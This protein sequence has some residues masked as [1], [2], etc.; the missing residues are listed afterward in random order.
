MHGP[1]RTVN[2]LSWDDVRL[3]LAL[4]RARTVGAAGRSLGID[5]STVSRR[6]ATLEELLA[7]KL[8]ERGHHG[9]V[10][11]EA[12]T[13]LMPVAEEI[14]EAVARFASAVDGLEHEV[15]GLVRITC[16]AD[17]AEV[18]VVPALPGLLARHPALRIELQPGEALAD[19][20]RRE[21]DIALRTV[22]PERGDLVVT[23]LRTVNWTLAA[24]PELARR[25]GSLRSWTDAAWIGWGERMAHVPPARWRD[26]HV[27]VE[28]LVCSD[29][30][31]VQLALVASG[32][33]VALVP[34]P[35]LAHF[36]L[37]PVKLGTQ[38]RATAADWPRN[39]LYLVTHRA[40]RDVPRVKVVWE[41]L[42]ETLR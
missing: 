36:G 4:C 40:L 9:V 37:V 35:G 41:H 42:L 3:F 29:S 22:R 6:L 19:L 25:L 34:E 38:L 24:A 15:S 11:T 5:G 30:L 28:P 16:P 10:P 2:R 17:A 14:E 7:A 20:A 32:L 21:A 33:G 31:R 8:F 26:Q 23:R 18:A 1:A 12:A 39:E 13:E 27:G